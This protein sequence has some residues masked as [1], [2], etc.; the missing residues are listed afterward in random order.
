MRAA[1]IARCAHLSPDDWCA[2]PAADASPPKWHLAHTSWFFDT[3]VLTPIGR[4]IADAS[5]Q[6]LFN[7]YYQT[8]G[9]PFPR[10]Q[11]GLI[12]RPTTDEVLAY[13]ENVDAAVLSLIPA[14]TTAQRDLVILGCQHEQ[15]HQELLLTDLKW[16]WSI[17]EI[18]PAIPLPAPPSPSFIPAPGDDWVVISEREHS[19]DI[20]H[21]G[22]GFAFDNESPRHRVWLRPYR[23]RRHL[24]SNREW[25]AF[26]HDGGYQR[27]E[28]WPDAGWHLAQRSGWQA[29]RYWQQRDSA[30]WHYTLYGWQ[31]IDLDAP[32]C[33]VSW[34]EAEAYAAWAG[35]RLP[36]EAEWEHA[37]LLA[38][39]GRVPQ[40][41]EPG[42]WQPQ[43]DFGPAPGLAQAFGAVWQ[44]TRSDYAPYP[45]YRP[46]DGAIGEYNGKFMSGQMVL[47]GASCATPTGHARASYRNFFPPDA[48]WQFS[49]LRL[50]QDLV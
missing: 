30:W 9:T 47:R 20:G 49:G 24:V 7:S 26:I 45:G 27:H 8:V 36:T 4:G 2:Q 43:A 16:A 21:H 50:A 11:R 46:A 18:Q 41:S 31:P 48:R 14:L 37:V 23:I 39:P 10:P 29:P 17:G 19:V 5:W 6:R 25:L 15:Q 33:H 13:R 42:W 12:L 32:V 22:P 44:W 34:H 40:P 3:F 1:S 28:L 38:H 35:A